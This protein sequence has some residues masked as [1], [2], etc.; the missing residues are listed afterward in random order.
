MYDSYIY[1]KSY[2][3][4]KD[5]ILQI[6]SGDSDYPLTQLSERIQT[7]YDNG[8]MQ[9]TQYDELMGYIQELNM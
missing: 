2:R 3:E 9:S 5:L 7:L 8:E 6:I 4:I 1:C